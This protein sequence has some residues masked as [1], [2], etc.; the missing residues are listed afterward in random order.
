MKRKAADGLF[1]KPSRKGSKLEK[2]IIRSNRYI[3]GGMRLR[4]QPYGFM[5]PGEG[6]DHSN[7]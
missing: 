2:G 5:G 3:G 1:T 4:I 7:L 6:T